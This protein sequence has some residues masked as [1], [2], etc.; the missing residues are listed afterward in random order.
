MRKLAGALMAVTVLFAATAQAAPE[1][2]SG[3]YGMSATV[4][5]TDLGGGQHEYVYDIFAEG[6]YNYY[7]YLAL[8]FDFVGAGTVTDHV[9]NMYDPGAGPAELREYWTVNG[10]FGNRGGHWYWGGAE[11]GVQASYGDLGTD[12]WLIDPTSAQADPERWFIDPVYAAAEGMANPF[13][14][15]SDYARWAGNGSTKGDAAYGLFA[16]MQG[17]EWTAVGSYYTPL[18]THLAF[19][20]TWFAGGYMYAGDFGPELMATIRIVSDLGP[21]GEVSFQY[22]N[23]DT[24]SMGPIVGPGV[25]E[26][27]A[28]SLLALGGLAAL[29]RRRRK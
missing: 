1:L 10:I 16:G 22:Y 2:A 20:M 17:D 29:R 19:D 5:Y 18:D 23:T 8:K 12:T 26:P 13:H 28:M 9:L 4:T 21:F 3:D 6:N 15:P 7:D 14:D 11:T 25:P 27:G 24:G